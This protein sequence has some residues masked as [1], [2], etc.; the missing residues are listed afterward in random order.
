MRANHTRTGK[1]ATGIDV[2]YEM[3]PAGPNQEPLTLM[4][5]RLIATSWHTSAR[6]LRRYQLQ[7]DLWF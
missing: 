7:V 3:K 1:S 4:S 5:T 2:R 6:H